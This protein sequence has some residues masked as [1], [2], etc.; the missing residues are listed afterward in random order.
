MT[1]SFDRLFSP[2]PIDPLSSRR[3]VL[4]AGCVGPLA[5][6]KTRGAHFPP[7]RKRAR[8]SSPV[9][10]RSSLVARVAPGDPARARLGGALA[11]SPSRPARSRRS[12]PP[13]APPRFRNSRRCRRRAASRAMPA[14]AADQENVA[15]APPG[16]AAG[17]A[18]K[19]DPRAAAP[20]KKKRCGFGDAYLP[21][22]IPEHLLLRVVPF[23]DASDPPRPPAPPL[24]PLRALG[25][26]RGR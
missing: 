4:L 21:A 20:E 18:R 23:S 14:P 1:G 2:P 19:D 11:R 10:R 17:A 12:R 25:T 24:L 15:P 9:A 26:A 13:R 8:R 22:S 5:F 16:D 7:A 3:S 6:A